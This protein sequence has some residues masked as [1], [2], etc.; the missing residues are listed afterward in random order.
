MTRKDSEKDSERPHYYS[1]FWLDVA[2]GRRII[3]APRPEEGEPVEPE[4]QEPELAPQRRAEKA[5]DQ[6]I[7]HATANGH[8]TE[9]IHVSAEPGEDYVSAESGEEELDDTAYQDEPSVA[10]AD[11]PDMDLELDEE[12]ATEDEE[13]FLDEED[14]DEDEDRNW[15]G[16]G[17]KKAKPT[18]PTKPASKKPGKRDS[19]RSY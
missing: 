13:E 10:D 6:D 8:S 17:R 16:R 1:Q 15:G 3:G 7:P 4:V 14:E 11:I 5:S 2:A 12:E 18:R 9:P 19:R